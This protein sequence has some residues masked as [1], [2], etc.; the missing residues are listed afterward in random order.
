MKE[1]ME[2][3]VRRIL[4]KTLRKMHDEMSKSAIKQK[5]GKFITELEEEDKEK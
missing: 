3:N 1:K 2:P 4:L 5:M